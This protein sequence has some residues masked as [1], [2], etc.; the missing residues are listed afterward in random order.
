MSLL[1][2]VAATEV[3]GLV[4]VDRASKVKGQKSMRALAATVI[5]P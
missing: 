1:G 2:T 3:I 4:I 5:D